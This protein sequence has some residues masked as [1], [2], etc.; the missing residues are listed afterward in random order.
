MPASEGFRGINF[1]FWFFSENLSKFIIYPD[2]THLNTFWVSEWVSNP[3]L[4][5]EK[6]V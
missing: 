1:H 2:V 5:K 4:L 6:S 3:N